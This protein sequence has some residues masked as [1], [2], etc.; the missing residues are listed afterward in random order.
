MTIISKFIKAA[1]DHWAIDDDFSDHTRFARIGHVP[2]D[3]YPAVV[4]VEH[5]PTT[6]E[7]TGGSVWN[8]LDPFGELEE[9]ELGTRSIM[10]VLSNVDNPFR[11]K[12]F[13]EAFLATHPVSISEKVLAGRIG[14][15]E[16]QVRNA[17]IMGFMSGYLADKLCVVV[18]GKHPM[19][20][21]GFD[22]WCE[23]ESKG[24]WPVKG[25][26]SRSAED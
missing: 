14:E 12:P 9:M 7:V 18:L 10:A 3:G 5:N 21:Y 4:R 6:G 25:K 17:R 19:E 15:S 11:Y 1:E 13:H 24:A 8:S 2:G 23:H 16:R 22:A 20:L 26:R